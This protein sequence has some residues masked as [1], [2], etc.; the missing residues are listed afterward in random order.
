MDETNAPKSKQSPHTRLALSSLAALGVVFGDIGT[1]PLYAFRLCFS[2]A[3]GIA[4]HPENILGVLSLVF[5]A[6][7]IVITVKYLL[8]ILLADF[9]GEGGVLALMAVGLGGRVPQQTGG[10]VVALGLAGAALLYGDGMITPAIS[11]LSAIEGLAIAAPQF[12]HA[13]IPLSIVILI[14]IF[15]VQRHGTKRIGHFFGPIMLVWFI[16]IAALGI[17]WIVGQVEVLSAIDPR[18]G[19]RFLIENGWVGFMVLGFVFLVVTGG[20]ALYADLGHFGLKPIRLGWFCIAMPAI[21]LNYFGQAALM[22]SRPDQ[23]EH[24]F[25][26]MAPHWFLYPLVAIAT[27]AAIIASQAVISGA[28]SLTYQAIQLGFMPRLTVKHYAADG[29]GQVYVPVV[30]GFLLVSTCFLVVGFGSSDSMAGAYGLA[31]SATMVITTIL[32]N[33]TFARRWGWFLATLPSLFFLCFDFS[34]LAAN[35]VKLEDGGWFPALI[36]IL[37]FGVMTTWAMGRR[38]EEKR[39]SALGKSAEGLIESVSGKSAVRTPGTGVFLDS[40]GIGFPKTLAAYYEHTHSLPE[41]VILM[42]VITD[43][44]PRIPLD[45]RVNTLDQGS[46]ILRVNVHY[47]FMQTPNLPAVLNELDDVSAE[48]R[49]EETTF[50]VGRQTGHVTQAKGMPIWRKQLYAFLTR[51]AE[52]PIKHYQLPADRVLE[53]GVRYRL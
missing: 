42:T 21:L 25:Y 19:I 3:T 33:I 50:F 14:G 32:A 23:V 44:V 13:V 38:V 43:P 4:P 15:A 46:G 45:Q 18:H 51:N 48:Y 11:V 16:V 40:R 8:Y 1:S 17:F 12:D 34:F 20:E 22:L 6:I 2:E 24:S 41:R 47:G 53:I 27:L 35:V 10:V 28:F 36:A 31:V 9:N 7:T 37:M 26:S 5:W 29:E 49:P 39:L 30:N 52:E